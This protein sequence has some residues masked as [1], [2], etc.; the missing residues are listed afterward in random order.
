M[1]DLGFAIGASGI[2]SERYFVLMKDMVNTIV[3][4][5]TVSPQETR[6]GLVDYNDPVSTAVSF[7]R[8]YNKQTFK[9]FVDSL[10]KGGT[11]SLAEGLRKVGIFGE[12]YNVISLC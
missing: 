10:S 2:N 7:S 4:M 5:Y 3:D 9:A 8:N 1:I 11:G 12:C 6:V